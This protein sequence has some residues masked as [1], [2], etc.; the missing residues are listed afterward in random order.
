[1]INQGFI[2]LDLGIGL[3]GWDKGMIGYS[4][5]RETYIY[6]GLSGVTQTM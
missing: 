1:M 5:E 2:N 3:S 4:L 6:H